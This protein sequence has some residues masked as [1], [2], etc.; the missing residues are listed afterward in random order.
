MDEPF[1][2]VSQKSEFDEIF[3]GGERYSASQENT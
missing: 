2:V 3:F 1:V